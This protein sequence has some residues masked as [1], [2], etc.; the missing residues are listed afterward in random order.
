MLHGFWAGRG[1]GNAALK[2]KLL[3]HLTAMGE[4][5]LFEVFL[6]LQKAYDALDRYRCLNILAEYRVGPRALR[7]LWT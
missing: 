3:Q 1:T 6:D 4:A 7:L 2:V 5:I